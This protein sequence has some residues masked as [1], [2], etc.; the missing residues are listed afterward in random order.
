MCPFFEGENWKKIRMSEKCEKMMGKF[1]YVIYDINR[2]DDKHR[3]FRASQFQSN[4]PMRVP[5]AGEKKKRIRE[6]SNP[7]NSQ[8]TWQQT[9]CHLKAIY[10][11]YPGDPWIRGWHHILQPSTAEFY[12]GKCKKGL[13]GLE[14]RLIAILACWWRL[15]TYW[16]RLPVSSNMAIGNP[17]ING[18]FN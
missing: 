7:F 4:R 16:T 1:Y 13:G 6:S 9:G 12:H 18:G 14:S 11:C 15:Y 17:P 5:L 8:L 2:Y 10:H 3:V